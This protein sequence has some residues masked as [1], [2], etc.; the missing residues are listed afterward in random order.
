MEVRMNRISLLFFSGTILIFV[1]LSAVSPVANS[2]PFAPDVLKITAPKVVQYTFDKSTLHIPI[3]VE[4]TTGSG[5]FLIFTGNKGIGVNGIENGHLGWHYV[6]QIDTCLYISN[7][8]PLNIGPS[9]I[10]WDGKIGGG[11]LPSA[12]TYTFYILA[13]D[14]VSPGVKATNFIDP[15]RF[16]GAHIVTE[17]VS[18][19]PLA[20]PVIFDALPTSS[21]EPVEVIRNKWRI[22]G[23][24]TDDTNLESTKY[25]STG[26]AP[27]L[28]LDPGD[29]S[30][31][32]FTQSILPNE[33]VLQKWEWVSNGEASL[34]TG[35]GNGGK[36]S[37]PS[38]EYPYRPSFGGP[39]SDNADQLFF[40]YLWPIEGNGIPNVDSGV[41]ALN[42][43]DGSLLRKIDLSEWWSSP[44]D[45]VYRPGF[46]EFSNGLL[47]AASPQAG[48]VQMIDPYTES[49]SYL[50]RWMN[51]YGD[52]IWDKTLPAGAP[53]KTWVFFGST[54]PPNPG[55]LSPDSNGFSLFPATGLGAAS[56]GIFTPDGTGLGYFP[57]PGM[58]DGQ[59]Y[60]LHVVDT[61]SA[62]DG[63]YYSGISSNGDSAGVWYRGY[64]S[65]KGIIAI[66]DVVWSFISFL[67]PHEGN[68]LESGKK[69]N[70]TW[71]SLG[72]IAIKLEFS[73]DGGSH[74]TTIADKVPAENRYFPW[75]VPDVNSSN[76]LIR[77]IDI[78]FSPLFWDPDEVRSYL[79]GKFTIIGTS[80]ISE[81]SGE[82]PR[83]FVTASNRPN[84]FNPST[85]IRY[86][87]GMPGKVSI[88]IYNTLGQ[89][90]KEIDLG[91]REK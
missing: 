84:P 9:E 42:I 12:G 76:C 67:D 1:F 39:V 38:S 33:V 74:W 89:Q 73:P 75:I 68:S 56:F 64:D 8:F 61:G 11:K 52:G 88:S 71:D 24:P 40:P 70:I 27:S 43:H 28:A 83:P 18:S 4:G 72:V 49:Q 44:P 16:A 41:A 30:K 23:A 57:I 46:L 87:L 17:D 47:L 15:N 59:V 2:Q 45:A 77:A 3:I 48:L 82:T 31:Y 34:Q 6:N 51:G 63:I 10:Q 25:T 53:E 80:G 20:N 19:Q 32:F 21:S 50:V 62:Y 26:E 55:S 91:Q 22:G 7:P 60:G 81:K 65:A 86:E 14:N 79:S 37:F 29:P 35:W 58:A 54:L 13:L 78:Y 36:V 69:L 66:P 90:V 85:T 5:L